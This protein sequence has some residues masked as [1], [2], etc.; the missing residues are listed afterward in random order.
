M[1]NRFLNCWKWWK[2]HNIRDQIFMSMLFLTVL[3]IGVLGTVSYHME[4]ATIEE[5]Y[6]HI[7]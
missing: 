4:K 7:L 1:K 2:R 6:R 3:A 5:N